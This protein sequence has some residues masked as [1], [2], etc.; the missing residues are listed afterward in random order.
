[1]G[2][3]SGFKGLTHSC[4]NRSSAPSGKLPTPMTLC[5]DTIHSMKYVTRV[6]QR[7]RKIYRCQLHVIFGKNLTLSLIFMFPCIMV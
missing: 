3:N 4:E 6:G 1:M 5:I 2:F 7:N